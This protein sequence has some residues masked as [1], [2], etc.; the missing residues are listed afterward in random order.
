[1]KP[2]KYYIGLI[3]NKKEEKREVFLIFKKNKK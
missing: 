1:M 2:T 3:K